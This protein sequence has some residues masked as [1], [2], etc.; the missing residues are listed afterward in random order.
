MSGAQAFVIEYAEV[1]PESTMRRYEGRGGHRTN[2]LQMALVT[3]GL[4]KKAARMVG[5][6]G[7]RLVP[8]EIV[9]KEPAP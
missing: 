7:A 3:S 5:G 8:V 4:S 1:V 2:D 6:G 9:V